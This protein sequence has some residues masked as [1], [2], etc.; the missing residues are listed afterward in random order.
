MLLPPITRVVRLLVAVASLSAGTAYSGHAQATAHGGHRISGGILGAANLSMPRVSNGTTTFEQRPG[1]AAGSWLNLPMGRFL[2]LEPQVQYS[3]MPFRQTAGQTPR[4]LLADVAI[5]SL[6]A[7]VFFKLHLGPVAV[8]LGGQVDYPISVV[9][10]PNVVTTESITTFGYLATGG[11]ELFARSRVS[12]YGRYVYG[13]TNLDN[14]ESVVATPMLYARS[15][16]A[17]MKLRVFGGRRRTVTVV[18]RVRP[19]TDGDKLDDDIDRC[20]LM[21]GPARNYGCPMPDSDIDGVTDDF[22]KCPQVAG[23]VRNEGC[24]PTDEDNDGVEDDQD[25]CPTVAGTAEFAG[26]LPPDTDRDGVVGDDDRCPTVAG[27]S[28]MRG[29]PKITAFSASAVTFASGRIALTPEGRRELDK[30]VAY[31]TSLPDISVRLEGHTDNVGTDV[32]NN[33][34]SE[35]RAQGAKYYLL[36]KG[37]PEA[38]I[39]TIGH[40]STRP[41]IGNGTA[42]GRAR[43]RRVDVVVR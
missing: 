25:R 8:L 27:I 29:C 10:D 15:V 23:R 21:M 4:S 24:Q 17:G 13:F 26:C 38:R 42:D 20:P 34:L 39:S 6:S 3:A 19:D 40:G 16:Q 5:N 1:W 31:L 32:I 41:T 36:S 2:S 35:R 12:L 18:P 22:D 33:P 7:P 43:N 11:V 30:V 14:R 9:D 28:A 37:I